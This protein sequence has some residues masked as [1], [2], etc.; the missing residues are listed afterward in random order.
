MSSKFVKANVFILIGNFIFRIGG[1]IYHF[2]MATLLPTY[3]YGILATFLTTL[4]IFQILSSGGIPPAIAKYLS[5]YVSLGENAL[6][7]QIVYS[8]LKVMA[9]LGLLFSL[10]L[11]FFVSPYLASYYNN[12]DYFIPLC[13][14]SLI[15]PFSIIAG[16]FRGSFQGLYK[17]EYIVASRGGEQGFMIIFSV[18]L[19]IMGLSVVGAI[20]GSVFGYI[21]S[22]IISFYL[23]KKYIL[24]IIPQPDE[25]VKFSF[26]EELK[27]MKKLIYFAIPVSIAALSEMLLLLVTT[28]IMP[29][30]LAPQY[31]ARFQAANTISRIPLMLPNSIATT[32]LPASASA[33]VTKNSD[34]LDKYISES[35]RYTLIVIIPVCVGIALLSKPILGTIYFTKPELMDGSLALSILIIGMGFY[36]IFSISSSIIQGIKNPRIPMYLLVIGAILTIVLTYILVP[37]YGIVGAAIGTTITSII[38]AIP[39]TIIILK[40]KE[41]KSSMIPYLKMI[42]SSLVMAVGLLGLTSLTFLPLWSQTILGFIIGV[43]IYFFVFLFLKGFRKRDVLILRGVTD[44]LGP[45]TPFFNKIYNLMIKYANM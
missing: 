9:I 4:G 34:L 35:Y 41:T 29:H 33:N 12:N 30:L 21:A 6:A 13:M 43:A 10:L 15:I 20:L 27:L 11:V 25:E 23:F 38:I 37:I 28:L 26:K 17:T 8:S 19:V 44:K 36:S 1:Y 32:I 5:E 18:I 31:I 14:I 45:L 7:R 24:N 40:I 3:S 16:A 2:L 22:T 42:F 39:A